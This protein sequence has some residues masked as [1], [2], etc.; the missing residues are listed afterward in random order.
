MPKE[1][2]KPQAQTLLPCGQTTTKCLLPVPHEGCF[3]LSSKYRLHKKVRVPKNA[4]TFSSWCLLP[5]LSATILREKR[6]Q[7]MTLVI[8]KSRARS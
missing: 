4:A 3:Q 2:H 7:N 5:F 8:C 6:D 1:T